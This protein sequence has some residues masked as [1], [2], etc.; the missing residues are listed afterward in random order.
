MVGQTRVHC[1]KVEGL[2]DFVELEVV[3]EDDQS[4][5]Q[6]EAIAKDLMNKLGIDKSR[7]ISCAYMDLLLQ[8]SQ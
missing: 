2:G 5:D 1:D 3:L 4:V 8:K 7:L 6:G